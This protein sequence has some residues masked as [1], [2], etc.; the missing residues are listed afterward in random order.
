MTGTSNNKRED[1]G[2]WRGCPRD[3]PLMRAGLDRGHV[4]TGT[5]RTREILDEKGGKG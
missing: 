3:G 4:G 1:T 2:W 5:T